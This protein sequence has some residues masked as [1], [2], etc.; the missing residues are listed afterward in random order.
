MYN[1]TGTPTIAIVL[2]AGSGFFPICDN[3]SAVRDMIAPVSMHAGMTV[4]CDE[5]QKMPLA[6]WGATIPTNPR[7]PQNEVTVAVI[8]LHPRMALSLIFCT[9]APDMV[10]NSSPNMMMSRPFELFRA[11]MIPTAK[12]RD[13]MMISFHPAFEKLPADQ[14]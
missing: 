5:V 3:R 8:R 9:G 2:A 12:V 10:A 1:I 14:L 6:M 4:L 11:M 13:M 7:G